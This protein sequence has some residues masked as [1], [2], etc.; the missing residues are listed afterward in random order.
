MFS[1]WTKK[2]NASFDEEYSSN[3]KGSSY[4]FEHVDPSRKF[5]YYLNNLGELIEPATMSKKKQQDYHVLLTN[6][7]KIYQIDSTFVNNDLRQ[8]EFNPN[9]LYL[10][11]ALDVVLDNAPEIE[12]AFKCYKCYQRDVAPTNIDSWAS[13][14]S[15]LS[16]SLSNAFAEQWC[17]GGNYKQL[18]AKRSY[19]R[20]TPALSVGLVICII[21]PAKSK[22]VLPMLIEHFENFKQNE[23]V[24]HRKGKLTNT[25]YL[26]NHK[27]P[28]YVYSWGSQP[29]VDM[30]YYKHLFSEPFTSPASRSQMVHDIGG[31]K[32]KQSRRNK[33]THALT[34]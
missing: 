14:G 27:Y 1:L 17:V 20:Q 4:F 26:D 22:G 6:A 10:V 5:K 33:K 16:A 32:N 19:F 28:V 29:I 18:P 11:K 12:H 7:L 34:K 15:Y 13:N 21:V 23:I 30:E 9:N 3:K 24:L 2:T 8:R 25:K 31:R